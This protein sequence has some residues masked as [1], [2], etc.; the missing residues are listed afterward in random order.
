MGRRESADQRLRR[1]GVWLL[2][3]LALGLYATG[4][5]EAS[6]ALGPD[7]LVARVQ[8]RYERTTRLQ[9]RFRQETRVPGFD[10]VQTG[11]GQVWILKPGMMRW[12]YTKP[13]RQTIIANGDTLWIYLPEDR[14]VI[15]DHIN[16]SLGTRTP[17][18]FLAGQARLTDLFTVAGM[19]TQGPGEGGL[20]QLELSPKGEAVPYTQVF[21]GID[22]SSYLVKLVRV[23]D[24]VGNMTAMWFTNIDTEAPVASS[25]F[26]FQVPP[27]IEVMAPPVFPGPR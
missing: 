12:D 19:A 5:S 23:I 21:L 27:G 24:G 22:P 1:L 4:V 10:Q 2:C 9:A 13:E 3:W 8:S 20:L 17:A 6:Q 15:R 14:Q 18:L 16:H 11:E 25:L 7:V 26:Q